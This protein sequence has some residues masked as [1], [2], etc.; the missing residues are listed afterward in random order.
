MIEPMSEKAA[1]SHK[2]QLHPQSETHTKIWHFRNFET[3]Q[4]A[5]TYVNTPPAQGPDEISA[6]TRPDGSVGMFYFL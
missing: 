6:A 4:D 5:L 3:V 1:P 2:A